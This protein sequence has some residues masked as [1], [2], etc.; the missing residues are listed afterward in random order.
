MSCEKK[1]TVPLEH[2]T[3]K[4]QR[5]AYRSYGLSNRVCSGDECTI[6][7]YDINDPAI[8]KLLNQLRFVCKIGG[9]RWRVCLRKAGFCRRTERCLKKFFWIFRCERYE[10]KFLPVEDHDYLVNLGI[11]CK[12]Y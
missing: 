7:K 6:K 4:D 12:S 1:I 11:V 3:L 9:K 5:L 10:T 8:R 2:S